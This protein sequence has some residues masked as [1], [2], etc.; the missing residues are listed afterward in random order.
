LSV[1]NGQIQVRLGVKAGVM[2]D[3][4][5]VLGPCM[6]V[7]LN[8]AKKMIVFWGGIELNC[9]CELAELFSLQM[10]VRPP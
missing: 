1:K 9:G 10:T 4:L 5:E 2:Y 8:F 7:R 3:L 6:G